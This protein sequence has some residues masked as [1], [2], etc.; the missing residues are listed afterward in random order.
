MALPEFDL[1]EALSEGGS[2]KEGFIIFVLIA[3]V[4]GIALAVGAFLFAAPIFWGE[5]IGAALVGSGSMRHFKKIRREEWYEA[6]FRRSRWHF[7]A[8][9]LILVLGGA[10]LQYSVPEAITIGDILKLL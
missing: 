6:A 8:L 4:I 5:V 9:F 10:F 3:V 1:K 2:D 7:L